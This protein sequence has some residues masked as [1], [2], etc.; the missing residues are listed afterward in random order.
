A[1]RAKGHSARELAEWART[2]KAPDPIAEHIDDMPTSRSLGAQKSWRDGTYTGVLGEAFWQRATH[3]PRHAKIVEIGPGN[4][5][6]LANLFDMQSFASA[7]P[8]VIA[9]DQFVQP[10]L[11]SLAQKVGEERLR[12]VE[13]NLDDLTTET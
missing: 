11:R 8:R 10:S 12:V 9:V 1:L 3:P 5:Y 6:A 7:E 4:G 13:S 2:V